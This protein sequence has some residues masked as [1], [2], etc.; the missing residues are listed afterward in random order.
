MSDYTNEAG[1]PMMTHSQ[2][3]LEA[4]LDSQSATEGHYD[5][6]DDE[7]NPRDD[8]DSD[9]WASVLRK[10]EG[11]T[12]AL[13]IPTEGEP[14]Y[15]EIKDYRDL[16][17][18]VECST[19]TTVSHSKISG[20][21]TWA[22]DEGLLVNKA[23]NPRASIVMGYPGVIA[24]NI[25]VCNIN[26]EGDNIDITKEIIQNVIESIGLKYDGECGYKDADDKFC[27]FEFHSDSKF[28]FFVNG[29]YC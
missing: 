27:N 10:K 6:R 23:Y 8:Y 17:K 20:C 26:K 11:L 21:Y 28:P 16:N 2:A 13:L 25:V 14:L 22:D 9:E 3:R 29:E 12:L 24:G 4:D 18:Y 15:V 19:G 1:E 7:P 5:D